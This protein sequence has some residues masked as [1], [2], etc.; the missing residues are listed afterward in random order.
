MRAAIY[1]R[2][3]TAAQAGAGHVSIDVQRDACE[4]YCAS[5][6]WSVTAVELDTESGLKVT[7]AGYQRIIEMARAGAIDCVVVMAAS[8]FG[9]KASEV[10][11]RSEELRALGVELH[12]TA[13]DLSNFLM[14]GIQAVINEEES[15]R[16][17]SR[18]GPARRRRA[19]EGYWL[20]HAPFGTR[21]NAGVL[22]PDDRFDI[23]RG[24]FERAAAGASVR[25][26]TLWANSLLDRPRTREGVR[27]VL[28]NVAY[29]GQTKWAGEVHAAAW[30]PLVD[31][32][33]WQRAQAVVSGRRNQRAA[34]DQER[35]HWLLG[36]AYC[37]ACGHRMSRRIAVKTWGT[38]YEYIACNRKDRVKLVVGCGSPHLRI[39][40]LQERIISELHQTMTLTRASIDEICDEFAR[41][42]AEAAADGDRRRAA[43]R[44]ERSRLAARIQK[45]RQAYFDDVY[46]RLEYHRA[47][48]G[49]RDGIA[50][51]DEQLAR[52]DETP[53]VDAAAF[54][55]FVSDDAWFTLADTDPLAFR[56]LLATF[57]ERIEVGPLR[58][59]WRQPI[60]AAVSA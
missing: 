41:V 40:P 21:N 19:A 29:A 39:R 57:I 34:I 4:H 16:L 38:R 48:N 33:L 2:V 49:I 14:L 7:R 42:H 55:A 5:R 17:A 46:D 11:V 32:A 25:Q 15:R 1:L 28:R 30:P 52:P 44:S 8:R 23:L 56:D 24:M 59:A 43:L 13:E 22:E 3:S 51:I 10:L 31:P 27:E 47:V 18:A 50:A 9:R 6:G 26:I 54:R 58:I 53:A 12:S 36:L 20:A 37:A 35:P 60:A 45:A